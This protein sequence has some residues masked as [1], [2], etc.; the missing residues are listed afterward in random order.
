MKVTFAKKYTCML[1]LPHND[2]YYTDNTMKREI[3]SQV[4]FCYHDDFAL[5]LKGNQI[6]SCVMNG[7]ILNYL[8]INRRLI[9]IQ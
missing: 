5:R 6:K 4:M 3:R 8:K 1:N 9:C 7:T 2:I